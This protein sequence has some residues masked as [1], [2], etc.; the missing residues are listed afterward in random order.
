MM[1][2]LLPSDRRRRAW[3]AA[4]VAFVF[5]LLFV[6]YVFVGTLATGLFLYYAVRPVNRRLEGYVSSSGR[7]AALTM[8]VVVLPLLALVGYVLAVGIQQVSTLDPTVLQPYVNPERLSDLSELLQS[9]RQILQR[10]REGG[11]PSVVSQAL[12]VLGSIGTALIHFFLMVTLVYYLLRDDERIANWFRESV[13]GESTAHAYVA[14]VD[15]D[16]SSVYFSNILLMTVVAVLSVVGYTLYNALAPSTVGIPLPIVLGVLTGVASIV[17][18]VVGKIVYVPIAVFLF[19]NALRAPESLLVYPVAFTVGAFLLLDL[20]PLTFVLPYIAGRTLHRGLM[21]F[22]YIG[23][24][25]LFG[26]YGIFLGPL[27][28]VAA[29]HFARYVVSDLLRG[30]DVHARPTAARDAGSDPVPDE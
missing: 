17:P 27:L 9:P 10:L 25:L 4:V 3:W 20:I 7:A 13:G 11:V 18:I 26:W 22:A 28:V 8:V 24:P 1:S 21:L 14:A 6:G 29:F 16:L 12:G 23:G 2:P 19:A 15:E 5:L 30:E